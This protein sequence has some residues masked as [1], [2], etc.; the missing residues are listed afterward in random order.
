MRTLIWTLE[1]QVSTHFMGSACEPG[2]GLDLGTMEKE[3]LLSRKP[4]ASVR[5]MPWHVQQQSCLSAVTVR[6]VW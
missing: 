4:Q 5:N 6:T 1:S 2:P 3:G